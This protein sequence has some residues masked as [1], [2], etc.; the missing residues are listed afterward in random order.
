MSERE[1]Q[2]LRTRRSDNLTFR[3]LAGILL[4]VVLTGGTAWLRNVS[5]TL[6]VMQQATI[7]HDIEMAGLKQQLSDLKD[8]VTEIK[9]ILRSRR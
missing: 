6:S 1:E 4:V 2:K 8:Q 9:S 7:A 3:W 5:D